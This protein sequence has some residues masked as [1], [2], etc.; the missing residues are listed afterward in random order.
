MFTGI[1]KPLTVTALREAQVPPSKFAITAREM[2]SAKK[3]LS[4]ALKAEKISAETH[5]E[6]MAHLA[7]RATVGKVD[8]PVNFSDA[9]DSKRHAH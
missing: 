3:A 1:S 7:A 9:H 5:S 6:A 8:A 4:A 2:T